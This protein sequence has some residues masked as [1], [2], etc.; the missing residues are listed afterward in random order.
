MHMSNILYIIVLAGALLIAP[1]VH[2]VIAY[3]VAPR[4]AKE[5]ILNALA[6]DTDFQQ[7]LMQSIVYNFSRP[8]KFKDENGN[9]FSDT[10]INIF[11]HLGAN[12]FIAEFNKSLNGQKESMT[13][14][15]EANA[16]T[17]MAAMP[18]NPLLSLAMQQIPKKY[19][20]YIQ[21]IA[22]LMLQGQPQ[23]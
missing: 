5:S 21:I 9:E 23:E 8:M 13:K 14:E 7:Q 16:Q 12:V 6:T 18:N 4:K 15:L 19:L 11:S 1:L 3:G 20:P 2:L 17:A 22:N 10:P